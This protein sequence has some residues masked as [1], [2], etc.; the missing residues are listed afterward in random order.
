MALSEL[1]TFGMFL[2]FWFSQQALLMG[3]TRTVRKTKK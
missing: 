2:V 3:R 1:D